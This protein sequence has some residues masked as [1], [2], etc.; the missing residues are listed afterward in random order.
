MWITKNISL[1]EINWPGLEQVARFQEMAACPQHQEYHAEGDVLTHTKMV[2]KELVDLPEFQQLS[3]E[4]QWIL[5][6]AAIFHDIGKPKVTVLEEGIWRAP[7]HSAVGALIAREIMYREGIDRNIRE[8]VCSLVRLHQKPFFIFKNSDERTL[9]RC[10]EVVSYN[11]LATFAKADNLGRISLFQKETLEYIELS[12][13]MAEDLNVVSEA[14]NWQSPA[15]RFTYFNSKTPNLGYVPYDNFGSK[16][17]LLS[18]IPGSGKTAYRKRALAH[19]PVVCLDDIRE[20]MG[21]SPSDNQGAVLQKAKACVRELLRKGEDFVWDSTNISPLVRKKIV[22]LFTDY[23][24]YVV[25]V[26]IEVPYKRVLSQNLSR[27]N[28][29]SEKV[30]NTMIKKW[31]PIM[32]W[33]CHEVKNVVSS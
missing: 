31:E 6:L 4:N 5:L 13:L 15:H 17:Y 8:T 27:K 3:S 22:S 1:S 19:L 14:Y 28:P 11:M 24:A 9:L 26:N 20:E 23:N 29:V 2:V 32:P 7:N 16:V 33:E 21:I 18:A 25:G 12:L 30:I 10:A